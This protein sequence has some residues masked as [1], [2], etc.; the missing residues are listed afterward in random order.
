MR[1]MRS[2]LQT[3]KTTERT[4][5]TL[6]S[7]TS[8][9][10]TTPN[11]ILPTTRTQKPTRRATQTSSS[12]PGTPRTRLGYV[13][14]PRLDNLRSALPRLHHRRPHHLDHALD[15]FRHVDA[16][17]YGAHRQDPNVGDLEHLVY[18]LYMFHH[19]DT[20]AY[21]AHRLNFIVGQREHLNPALDTFR[22]VDASC[23][24][25]LFFTVSEIN[26]ACPLPCIY[27]FSLPS[28]NGLGRLA[29]QQIRSQKLICAACLR[30]QSRSCFGPDQKSTFSFQ[31]R[32]CR[33]MSKVCCQ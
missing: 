26:S 30:Q 17:N 1:C 7:A 20:K 25:P 6:S 2:D 18:A 22:L 13:P 27:L 32:L 16:K 3:R 14:T 15:T 31:C 28:K 10:Q 4:I 8:I 24:N 9:T 5:Q 12:P 29:F 33:I 21:G 11:Q 19:L 23:I